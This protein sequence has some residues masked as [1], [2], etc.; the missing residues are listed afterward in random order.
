H[1]TYVDRTALEWGDQ[2]ASRD[3]TLCKPCRF[4]SHAEPARSHRNGKETAVETHAVDCGR[5]KAVGREPLVP[6]NLFDLRPDE[7]LAEQVFRLADPLCDVR[8][9]KWGDGFLAQR[10]YLDSFAP[11]LTIN[12][13]NI[14]IVVAESG[15]LGAGREPH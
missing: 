8:R 12:N 15:I 9:A 6:L 4:E 3:F 10:N 1:V 2:F 11:R 7:H 14:E 5:F 13:I